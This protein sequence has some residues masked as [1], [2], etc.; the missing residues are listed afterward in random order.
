MTDTGLVE[1][2]PARLKSTR[3]WLVAAVVATGATAWLA[4]AWAANA[5]IEHAGHLG[6]VGVS[7]TLGSAEV[8][9]L[10]WQ[11]WTR[12]ERGIAVA[13]TAASSVGSLLI[14]GAAVG[15]VTASDFV[16]CAS[17]VGVFGMATAVGLFGVYRSTGKSS[18]ATLTGMFIV[19]G[20]AYFAS[21]LWGVVP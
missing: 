2:L 1:S 9:Y 4:V 14:L 16:A 15:G 20:L 21:V 3:G 12:R 17:G 13:V 19:F 7:L 10:A 8:A 6:L 11:N 18:A 5:S